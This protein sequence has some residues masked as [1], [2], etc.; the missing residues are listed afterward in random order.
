MLTHTHTSTAPKRIFFPP[1]SLYRW[2]Y[3]SETI[4]YCASVRVRVCSRSVYNS[5]DLGVRPM[6]IRV[7][8]LIYIFRIDG[9]VDDYSG[10][11]GARFPLSLSL[12]FPPNPLLQEQLFRSSIRSSL[13]CRGKLATEWGIEKTLHRVDPADEGR[14]PPG[15]GFTSICWVLALYRRHVPSVCHDSAAAAAAAA[16]RFND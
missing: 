15:V 9:A 14:C 3:Q 6:C 10:T 16:A 4:R 2:A 13:L 1:F 7:L 5:I 12:S 11:D 8:L